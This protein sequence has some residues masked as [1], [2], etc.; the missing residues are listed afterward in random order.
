MLF[1]FLYGIPKIGCAAGGEILDMKQLSKKGI[2]RKQRKKRILRSW[3]LQTTFMISAI[4]IPTASLIMMQNGWGRVTLAWDEVQEVV[5]D[6]EAFAFRGWNV[7]QGLQNSRE[8]LSNNSLVR[9]VIEHTKTEP[10]AALFASWCPTAANGG[11]L[12]FL[13]EAIASL[14]EQTGSLLSL[15]DDY[16]P[17]NSEAFLTVT[18]ATHSVDESIQWFFDNDWIWKMY[19]MALNVLNI[20]LLFCVYI[21]SKND[22]IHLPTIHYLTFLVVP[23]FSVATGLL[24]MVTASS[25]VASLLNADFC[26]GGSG[27]GSPQ[28]T[29]RDAILSY[30]YG[31]VSKRNDMTGTMKLVYDSFDFYAEVCG[32]I[33]ARDTFKK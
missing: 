8:S 10:S 30:Q 33:N 20:F 11:Q 13:N 6:A 17:V 22:I 3:R 12:E 25:G 14:E 5:D 23:L 24:L 28:G 26:A 9:N 7:L 21:F 4:L 15:F 29:I 2:S 27:E 1:K 16:V 31:S 18:E 19:I 32:W